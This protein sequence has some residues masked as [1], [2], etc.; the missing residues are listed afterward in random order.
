[1]NSP[2]LYEYSTN[3]NLIRNNM[4][5]FYAVIKQNLKEALK[6]VSYL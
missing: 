2:L 3:S 1:M 6:S 4:V 5:K